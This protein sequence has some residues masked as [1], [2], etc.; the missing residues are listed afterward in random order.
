MNAKQGKD[1]SNAIEAV[2]LE[3]GAQRK[4]KDAPRTLFDHYPWVLD[5]PRA[6]PLH[7]RIDVDN[8]PALYG[9]FEDEKRGRVLANCNPYSGKW[10]FHSPWKPSQDQ[11]DAFLNYVTERLQSFMEPAP[12]STEPHHKTVAA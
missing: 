7:L 8:S 4:P 10:S 6:G 2:L 9:V 5:T 1:F 11:I 12:A 3:L